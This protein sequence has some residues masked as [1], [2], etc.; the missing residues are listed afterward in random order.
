MSCVASDV[1]LRQKSTHELLLC[2]RMKSGLR[3]RRGVQLHSLASVLGCLHVGTRL[4]DHLVNAVLE[5]LL[6]LCLRECIN[7]AV[8]TELTVQLV[9]V[10][11]G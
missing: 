9:E 3:G 7:A 8:L 5:V 6:K 10:L 4:V 1:L 11:H 2:A